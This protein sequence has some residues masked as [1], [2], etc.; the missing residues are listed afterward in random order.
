MRVVHTSSKRVR[1]PKGHTACALRLLSVLLT[2]FVA[3]CQVT[4]PEGLIQ[5]GPAGECPEGYACSRDAGASVC[6]E[7]AG[8]D[9]GPDAGMD[10]RMDAGEEV[11]GAE[12]F[13][14]GGAD[15]GDAGPG[16]DSG[17]PTMTS[18]VF[19]GTG[20][21]TLDAIVVGEDGRIYIAGTTTSTDFCSS[22]PPTSCEVESAGLY[23]ACLERTGDELGFEWVRGFASNPDLRVGGIALMGTELVVGGTFSSG[24]IG[25]SPSLSIGGLDAFALVL[26]ST[27]MAVGAPVAWGSAGD[28][29]LEGIS[30]AG[31]TW[32]AVGRAGGPIESLSGVDEAGGFL[33]CSDEIT[34]GFLLSG[35]P[36]YDVDMS[37]SQSWIAWT[38]P[39]TG[40]GAANDFTS[41][42]GVGSDIRSVDESVD[43]L[44]ELVASRDDYV[45]LVVRDSA[46]QATVI[47]GLGMGDGSTDPVTSSWRV[48]LSSAGLL[49]AVDM[50]I[51]ESDLGGEVVHVVGNFA[52]AGGGAL[53]DRTAENSGFYVVIRSDDNATVRIGGETGAVSTFS[54]LAEL[55]EEMLLGG[56][57]TG[58]LEFPVV[59]LSAEAPDAFLALLPHEH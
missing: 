50:V 25:D 21:E 17:P 48:P 37:G 34:K 1:R 9:A 32:C 10:A 23:V 22:L 14:A 38:I 45:A 36:A 56:S 58:A 47:G 35:E 42:G 49:Q 5:C 29:T 46:A 44:G 13:D 18:L 11:D 15:V 55:D 31:N 26:E 12:P 4:L 8:S 52:G 54:A 41:A 20:A 19:G 27:G 24:S 3:A 16:I 39:G 53:A 2:T 59:V 40:R 7:G 6:V 30:A 51:T 57:G 43:A 28:D 33:L